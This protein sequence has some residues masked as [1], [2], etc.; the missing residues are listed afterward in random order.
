[1]DSWWDRLRHALYE[2]DRRIKWGLITV[3]LLNLVLGAV[4]SYP[5]LLAAR[6]LEA[7]R[8]E[9]ERRATALEQAV[10]EQERDASAITC[11]K[12]NLIDF[13]EGTLGSKETRMTLI[14]RDIRALAEEFRMPVEN[15]SFGHAEERS[16]DLVHFQISFPLKGGYLDLKKFLR[17]IEESSHFLIVDGIQLNTGREGGVQL[18]L[19]VKLSTYFAPP[20]VAAPP[21]PEPPGPEEVQDADSGTEEEAPEESMEP[22]TPEGDAPAPGEPDRPEP[23]APPVPEEGEA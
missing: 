19:N 7:E 17:R 12:R 13:Y 15:V 4:F 23:E 6:N 1:M 8:A 21:A 3:L 2:G 14:Q 11:G 18:G 9:L 5:S 22:E 20:A 16:Q 10:T